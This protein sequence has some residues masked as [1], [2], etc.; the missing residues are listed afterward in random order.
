ME[1]PAFLGEPVFSPAP[2]LTAGY[3]PIAHY[4]SSLADNAAQIENGRKDGERLSTQGFRL[5]GIDAV[6]GFRGALPH[7]HEITSASF[8]EAHSYSPSSWELFE[9]IYAP[10]ESRIDPRLVRLALSPEG[11][12]AGYCFAIPDLLN[13]GLGQFIVKTLAVHPTWRC[14]R[15][16]SWL[17]GAAHQEAEAAGYR[18]GGIHALM[19]AGS[20]SRAI[21]SHG[22]TIFR[23]YALY[24]KEL[25]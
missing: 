23:R 19:W 8:R 24:E 12:V 2:F 11:K 14:H 17:V 16:G 1:R 9:S 15:L 20:H 18:S 3:K 7:F 13:P 5:V 22:G 10:L 6:G 25:G 21:S 4:A